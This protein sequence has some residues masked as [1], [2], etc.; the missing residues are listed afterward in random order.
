MRADSTPASG[1]VVSEASLWGGSWGEFLVQP[2]D[3]SD[4]QELLLRAPDKY[5]SI[6]S[7]KCAYFVEKQSCASSVT[8]SP[9]GAAYERWGFW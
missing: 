7:C 6:H 9:L 5:E 3:R 4:S 2:S 8:V 1:R